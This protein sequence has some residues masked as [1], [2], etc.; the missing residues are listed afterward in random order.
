MSSPENKRLRVLLILLILV[1][2][3]FIVH[4]HVTKLP[5]YTCP[6]SGEAVDPKRF[7]EYKGKT[8]YFCCRVCL[9]QFERNPE[10]YEANVS[11]LN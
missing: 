3:S 9:G 11:Q 10:R 4:Y 5:N 8:I 1:S 6:V 2:F 7:T